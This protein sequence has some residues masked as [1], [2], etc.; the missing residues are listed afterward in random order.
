MAAACDPPAPARVA[1]VSPLMALYDRRDYFALRDGLA[2]WPGSSKE[3]EVRFLK[4]AVQHAFHQL[5][6]SNSNI[7]ELLEEGGL[8]K[9]LVFKLR[10]LQI[11]NYARL[12]RYREAYEVSRAILALPVP[13]AHAEDVHDV[14]NAA[15]LLEALV[16]VGPQQSTV[17]ETTVLSLDERRHVPVRIGPFDRR[18]TFDTGANFSV[19]MRSEAEALGLPVRSAGVK[20]GTST[21]VQAQA[22]VAVADDMTIGSIDYKNVVFLVFPDELLSFPGGFSIPGIIGFPVIEGMREVTF[23]GRDV[24]EISANPNAPALGNLALEELYPLT[25]VEHH[26]ESLLC[27]LDTGASRTNFYEPFF[28]RNRARIESLGVRTRAPV[29]GVGGVREMSAFVLPQAELAVGSASATLE[30][31]LVYTESITQAKDNYLLCNLG[32]DF[33]SQFRE[34]TISFES[35]S[36]VLK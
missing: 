20:V 13:A 12:Y 4:A 8:D 11:K 30:D 14:E 26:G 15:R 1:D 36:L 9:A 27:R 5:E 23:R 35:M 19:L 32:M 22:D 3:P 31:V 25:R 21:D 2:Q 17:R 34:Y 24:L 7:R 6:E 10:S 29:G 28:R 18:Y 33:L 16:E